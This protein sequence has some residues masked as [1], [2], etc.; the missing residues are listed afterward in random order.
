[1]MPIFQF[2]KL[3]DISKTLD[4]PRLEETKI[5]IKKSQYFLQCTEDFSDAL[6]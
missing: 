1:M 4:A 5:S 2:A 6:R 3:L